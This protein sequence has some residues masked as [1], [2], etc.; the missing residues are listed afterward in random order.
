LYTVKFVKQEPKPIYFFIAFISLIL[1]TFS[2]PYHGFFVL[3]VFLIFFLSYCD[4]YNVSYLGFFVSKT[5]FKIIIASAILF[6]FFIGLFLPYIFESK[7]SPYS[8][9]WLFTPWQVFRNFDF[10]PFSYSFRGWLTVYKNEPLIYINL[11]FLYLLIIPLIFKKRFSLSFLFVISVIFCNLYLAFM[12]HGQRHFF[13]AR[14]IYPIAP[15]LILNIVAFLLFIWHQINTLTLVPKRSLTIIFISFVIL[16]ILPLFANNLLITTNS[17]LARSAYKHSTLYHART[18][19]LNNP[20]MFSHRK[21]LFD[22]GSPPVPPKSNWVKPTGSVTWVPSRMFRQQQFSQYINP[23]AQIIWVPWES[24]GYSLDFIKGMELQFLILL[25]GR[26]NEYQNYIVT[27]H[28]KLEKT[29]Q[30]SEPA[31]IGLRY[32]FPYVNDQLK[33]FQTTQKLIEIHRNPDVMI[34]PTIQFFRQTKRE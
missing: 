16:S 3:P 4:R 22:L 25:N 11:I 15:L 21:M 33:S 28:F 30:A 9:Q 5:F 27:K 26:Y 12:I 19:M 24:I 1:T 2:K 8:S 14:Y 32:W 31:L 7:G 34:G 10:S 20:K 13:D 17:L 18:F 29:F 6:I 23:D